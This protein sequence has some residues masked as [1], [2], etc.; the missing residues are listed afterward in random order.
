MLKIYNKSAIT[1]NERFKKALIFGILAAVG[2]T[3]VYVLINNVLKTVEFSIIFILLG[4]AIGY[5]VKTTGRGVQ[6]KFSVL[7]AVLCFLIIVFGDLF[8]FFPSIIFYPQSWIAGLGIVFSS[9]ASISMSTILSLLFRVYAIYVA[10]N[11]GRII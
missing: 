9:Y 3:A 7:A 8:T 11:S 6:T 5:V 1:Q 4:Y 10:Y 2:L